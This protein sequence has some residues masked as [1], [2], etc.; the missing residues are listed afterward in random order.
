MSACDVCVQGKQS[1]KPFKYSGKRARAP[2]ELIHSDIC[3]PMLT[4][5]LSGAKF[6]ITFIDDYSR[7]R[8]VYFLKHK[9]EAI[10]AFKN[11]KAYAE[12]KIE[13]RIKFI[14]TNNGREYLSKE[15]KDLLKSLKGI[16]H[17]TTVPYSPQQND[18]CC[19]ARES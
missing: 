14:R 5:S 4:E 10:E 3:G 2:L 8:F 15:F 6:F 17:Q 16:A 12:N 9:S 19:R 1:R 11:F 13:R 7:K 18:F